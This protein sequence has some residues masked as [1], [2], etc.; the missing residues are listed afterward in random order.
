VEHGDA[1]VVDDALAALP[2]ARAVVGI[3][4]VGRRERLVEAAAFE[5]EVAAREQE[6]GRAVVNVA[7]V[8]V[9]GREGRAAAPVA[10]A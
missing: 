3:F 6:D 4:V 5:E 1:R 9:L 7:P 8:H 10:E 2:E